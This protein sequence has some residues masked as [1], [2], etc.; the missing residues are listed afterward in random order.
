MALAIDERT[1]RLTVQSLHSAIAKYFEQFLEMP[2]TI[3]INEKL[4]SRANV[5]RAIFRRQHPNIK[6]K[7][8]PI[9]DDNEYFCRWFLSG[10][11]GNVIPV[12]AHFKIEARGNNSEH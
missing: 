12:N 5:I 6:L 4:L 2:E 9:P 8:S 11:D 7:I 1:N 3:F 10:H